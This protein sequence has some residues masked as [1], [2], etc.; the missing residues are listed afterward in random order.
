MNSWIKP[1]T[2][3][4]KIH[5]ISVIVVELK[6]CQRAVIVVSFLLVADVPV[7]EL[8]ES[9]AHLLFLIH[10]DL[11]VFLFPPLRAELKWWSGIALFIKPN[12]QV[13]EILLQLHIIQ[14]YCSLVPFAL[15]HFKLWMF[16]I[17]KG[18]RKNQAFLIQ[19]LYNKNL[20]GLYGWHLLLCHNTYKIVH[21]E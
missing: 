3:L 16:E 13:V 10:A 15:V 5:Q 6:Y 19:I 12:N 2:P 1:V 17:G 7:V 9:N 11:E 4:A 14:S 20:A 18:A 8:G 21:I